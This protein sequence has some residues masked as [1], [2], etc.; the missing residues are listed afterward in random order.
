MN[1]IMIVN[2]DLGWDSVVETF[3]AGTVSEEQYDKLEEICERND[4]ILIDWRSLSS[5]ESFL[6]EN[7]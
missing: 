7:E 6:R 3:D 5:V 1:L 2:T 4:Y